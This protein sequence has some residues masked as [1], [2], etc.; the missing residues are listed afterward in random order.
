M[1]PDADDARLVQCFV[2]P[3]MTKDLRIP[4]ID[5]QQF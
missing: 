3:L 2:S 5:D 4:G 1:Y